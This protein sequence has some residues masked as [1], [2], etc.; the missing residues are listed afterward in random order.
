MFDSSAGETAGADAVTGGSSDGVRRRPGDEGATASGGDGATPRLPD[1]FEVVVVGPT[2]GGG[3]V[4]YITNQTER[5]TD[6]VSV[7]VHDSGA[8]PRG[9]GPV[10][11]LSGLVMALVALVRFATRSPPDVVH[12]HTSHHFSF[13]RKGLYVFFATYVWDVPVLVHVHGSGFDEFVATDNRLV[14]AYQR[15]VFGACDGIIVLSEHW[16][17]VVAARAPRSKLRVIPNA[18]DPGAYRAD[19][20]DERPHLVLVSNLIERKGVAELASAVETLADR[21][22]DGFRVSIAGDGPLSDRVERLAATHEEVTYHGYVS[23]ERKRELLADGS[24]YVLPTY[25]EGLPIAML[26]G[27]AGANAVVST[28]VAAIPEVI[29]DDRGILV[30]PGDAEAL[31]DALEA[32]LTD[33]ERRTRMAENNRRAVEAE[34]SWRSAIDELLRTYATYA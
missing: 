2:H 17:D 16:K 33:P 30:E 14:A 12:V 25:A 13:Y 20:T 24:I 8:P 18:V 27:M 23:E 11:F 15:A 3:I 5:L 21:H 32:L 6:H 34:Y 28:E 19:P 7:T 4:S 31:V 26:E 10:R 22:P 29:D 1:D 9:S